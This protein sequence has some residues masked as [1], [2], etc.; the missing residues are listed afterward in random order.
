LISCENLVCDRKE[1][2]FDTFMHVMYQQLKHYITRQKMSH[3]LQTWQK[4]SSLGATYD[5]LST[6]GG[7]VK[8][9]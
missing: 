2:I 4:L 9:Q 1:F 6:S 5:I 7:Q 8:Q 3:Q